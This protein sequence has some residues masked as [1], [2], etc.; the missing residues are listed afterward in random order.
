MIGIATP[1]LLSCEPAQRVLTDIPGTPGMFWGDHSICVGP[2]R[3]SARVSRLL[4]RQLAAWLAGAR[5]ALRL[6]RQR[7]KY[8][9]VVSD[10]GASGH[11][12]AL[13]QSAIPWG[14]K[15]HVMVDCNWYRK[16]SRAGRWLARVIRRQ[17]ARS[18]TYFAVWASHEVDDYARVF[19]I[20]REKLVYV[21]HYYSLDGYEFTVRDQGY[22]FAGGNGDRDYRTLVEAVRPLEIPTWIATTNRDAVNGIDIPAHV[23]VE[24]TTHAGFRQGI[25]ALAW[26]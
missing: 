20:P 5:V 23:R 16:Q 21:P 22:I 11:L 14:R 26:W 25:A 8:P 6:L 15:P 12:F 19:D 13:L 1:R 10:G 18:T 4:G 24:G 3:P 9:G 7:S 17:V 2:N